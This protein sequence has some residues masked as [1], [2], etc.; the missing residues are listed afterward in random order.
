MIYLDN[1]AN[2]IV[3][4]KVL[5]KYNEITLNYIGN[6]NSNHQEGLKAKKIIDDASSEISSH[7]NC[8]SEDVIYTSGS[9]EANNLV[10]KGLASQ[11]N[12]KHIIISA[13]EHSSIV[14]PVNY[15]VSSGYDVDVIGLDENG[16]V[17]VKELEQKINDD[18][19][20]VSICSV[21]SELGTIEP[22]EEIKAICKKHN[23]LFHTDATQAIGKIK[24]NYDD[25]DFI[26]F[27]PHKFYGLN[28]MGVLIN[29][30]NKLIPLIHGGKSTT[31]YRSGTP[32]TAAIVATNE[33]L[34]LANDNLDERSGYV[35]TLKDYL[36]NELKNKEYVH[37]NSVSNSIPHT[38]NFSLI[39]I[40]AKKVVEKLD[41]AGICVSMSSACSMG[42]M[43]KSVFAVTHDQALASNTVRVSMS[44]LNTLEEI[45]SFIIILDKIVSSL[46]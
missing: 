21:D 25:I 18:T 36:I 3:D 38:L 42:G 4:P 10:I 33:A 17:D 23:V 26:T 37:I 20:L 30:G 45:K 12:K 5:E 1:A 29:K 11:T 32:V 43:S 16:L 22:I 13:V 35:K 14:S 24:I 44:Y 41:E 40:D 46:R 27:A 9:S 28:G 15:L 39:N 2:T 31:V 6:P 8:K 7:F 34:K 19:F